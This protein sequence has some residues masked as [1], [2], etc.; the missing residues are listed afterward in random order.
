MS[1]VALLCLLAALVLLI[2]LAIIDLRT[3]LLPDKLVLP[4]ALAGLVFHIS[5]RFYYI[6]PADMGLGLLIG[7]GLLYAV[8]VLANT[9]YKQDALGLGD[10]K[11]LAAA[12]IWLGPQDVLLAIIIGAICGVAHGLGLAVARKSK[13]LAALSLPA[14]PGFAGGILVAGIIKFSSFFDLFF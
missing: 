13:N 9:Y 8:R 5:I 12:G 14:G 1:F 6:A 11:L 10:V 2:A 3:Y 4:F 7:G